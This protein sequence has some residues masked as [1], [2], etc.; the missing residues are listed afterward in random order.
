MLP[1]VAATPVAV[2]AGAPS[3]Q[4]DCTPEAGEMTEGRNNVV[5]VLSFSKKTQLE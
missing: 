4:S 5:G 3:R 1:L 2:T